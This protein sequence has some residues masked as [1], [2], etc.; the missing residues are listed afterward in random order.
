MNVSGANASITADEIS[1]TTQGNV[2]PSNGNSALGAYNGD[3]PVLGI[4]VGGSLTLT[5]TTISTSGADAVGVV[6]NSGGVTNIGGGSVATAGPDAHALFVTGSGSKAN[7]SGSGSFATIGAGAIGLYATLGGVVS[8]TGPAT[9]TITTKGGVSPATG[10]GAYGVNADGAG[11]AVNLASATITTSGLGAAALYASDLAS[12]GSAGTIAASGTL[13][14][15]TTNASTAAVMLEGNGGS[16]AATGG[17]TIASAGDAIEFTNATNAVATFDNFTID[18]LSGD[19]IF[20]DPSTATVNFNGTT[21]NAGLNNLLDATNGSA[22]TLNANASALT[23]A[24]KTDPTS[25]TNVNLV[26][27]TKWTMTGSSNVTNLAVTNSV[28]V[29]APPS[30]GGGF[31]TLT[32]TN[33]TGSGANIAMNAT[34]GGGTS[35]AD[36]IIVNGGKAS[37]FTL[38]TIN[39]VGGLGGATSGAGIPLVVAANGGTVA[40]GAFAL[41]NTPL[42]GGFRYMLQ[43]SNNN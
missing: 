10:L 2:N 36:Q 28:V 37:G 25:T 15:N 41:A 43:E 11:S 12:T 32:V 19:L 35:A 31:K 13:T 24:I 26:N 1:I 20:A 38:L 17:G 42:A 22:I 18:N 16:I 29:F 14:V 23:G 33:Y 4:P 34:L 6:T 9:T 40:P 27:G 21:A 30:E 3:N 8:A 5:N 39:N 7:L